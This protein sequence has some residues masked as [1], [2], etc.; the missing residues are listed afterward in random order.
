[1]SNLPE[2]VVIEKGHSQVAPMEVQT[3]RETYFTTSERGPIK[4][5]YRLT[6]LTPRQVY[7]QGEAVTVVHFLEALTPKNTLYPMGPKQ[8]TGEFVDEQLVTMPSSGDPEPWIPPIY[9]GPTLQ[10]PGV[11]G[12]F[13][14]TVYRFDKPGWHTIIWKP[15][16]FK[17]NK[18]KIQVK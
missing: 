2:I 14:A 16:K 15:G 17:S 13:E 5:G 3:L 1:M 6:I 8:I 11:D 10:G 18:I 4:K 9:D 7:E 12:H